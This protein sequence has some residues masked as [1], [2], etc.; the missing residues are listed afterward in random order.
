MCGRKRKGYSI[1]PFSLTL[2][3]L[4]NCL[5]TK[6]YMIRDL[7][8]RFFAA[9]Q[10]VHHVEKYSSRSSYVLQQAYSLAFTTGLLR[11]PNCTLSLSELGKY[12]KLK[13]HLFFAKPVYPS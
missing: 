6:K 10:G 2:F 12:D 9:V 1:F 13:S 11:G 7:K 4:E 8:G 5:N 3:Y